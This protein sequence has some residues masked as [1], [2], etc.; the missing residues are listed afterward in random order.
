MAFEME[1]LNERRKQRE[2]K[3]QDRQK[4]QKKTLMRLGIAGGVL[5]AC[6][7]LILAV[8][9]SGKQPPVGETTLSTGDLPQMQTTTE[10]EEYSPTTVIHFTA[11]GDLNITDKVVASGGAAFDYTGAFLDVLPLLSEADLTA[12]NLEGNACGEPYGKDSAPQQLLSALK[13]TGVDILQ[14]A[15]SKSIQRGIS[16]LNATLQNVRIAGFATVGAVA[17]EESYEDS[18]VIRIVQGIRVAVVAFTKG[19]DGMALPAGSENRVNLLYTDYSSTYKKVDNQGIAKVL[20]AVAREEPDVTIAMLHWGS[21]HSDIH[22]DTQNAIRDLMFK[23]GVDAIIGTHPHYVQEMVLDEK[24]GTFIAY[25]LGDFFGDADRTGTDYSVVLDLEITKDNET[26]ETKVTG[27]QYTPIYTAEN[28]DGTL[29]IV[30]LEAAV[31]A[32]EAGHIDR[33]SQESYENMLYGLQ[34][35]ADRVQPKPQEEK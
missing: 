1:E 7:I 21:E 9:L 11:A 31:A 12:L 29:R 5:I 23:E 10:A 28:P 14:L 27:F 20:R 32:Y 3:K 35:I 33:V 8:G 13:A 4:Q 24:K 34:R 17:P 30:R 15:N 22:S 18:F 19:M 26:G 2:Q 25:S 16:G 6:S